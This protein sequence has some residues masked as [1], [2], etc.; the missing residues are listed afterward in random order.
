MCFSTSVP[1]IFVGN[2]DGL[3]QVFSVHT[4]QPVSQALALSPYAIRNIECFI[5][6]NLIHLAVALA[7]GQVT[8]HR[9]IDKSVQ[10]NW[11]HRKDSYMIMY[12]RKP[13]SMQDVTKADDQLDFEFLT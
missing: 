11:D 6:G 5:Y 8:L 2:A 9:S 3:L 13:P 4:L 10:I 12:N 1:Y 7:S